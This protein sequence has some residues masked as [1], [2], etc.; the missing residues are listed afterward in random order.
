[1]AIPWLRQWR[2]CPSPNLL[3]LLNSIWTHQNTSSALA[4]LFLN[5]LSL[6]FNKTCILCHLDGHT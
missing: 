1:A 2:G 5:T 3:V 4:C 6:R